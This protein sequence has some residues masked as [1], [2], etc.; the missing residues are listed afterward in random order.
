MRDKM[1]ADTLSKKFSQEIREGRTLTTEQER[2]LDLIQRIVEEDESAL[3]ALYAAYGQRMYAYALRLTDH[4]QVAEDVVQDALVAV[5]Q[6]AVRF[7][8][9]GRVLAWL[10]GI[11]HHTAKK[12]LRHSHQPITPE[13][14]ATLAS[15]AGSP[16]ERFQDADHCRSGKAES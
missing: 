11:V 2:D 8:S 14:E 15:P 4:P 13:M 12:A 3:R 5:W 7:R 10:L 9:E 1:L 16:E 6:S